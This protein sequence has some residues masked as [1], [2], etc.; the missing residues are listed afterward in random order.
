MGWDPI[1]ISNS[2]FCWYHAN[3]CPLIKVRIEV[4]RQS[5][6]KRQ[7]GGFLPDKAALYLAIIDN[8]IQILIYKRLKAAELIKNSPFK[9]V[10]KKH[11]KEKINGSKLI[12][13]LSLLSRTSNSLAM[14][15]L[16]NVRSL[17]FL[18]PSSRW[19]DGRVGG[20]QDGVL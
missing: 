2:Y 3:D 19:D 11:Y 20:I 13:T 12:P 9:Y 8:L 18:S 17:Y 4:T 7:F 5:C 14:V 6:R 15:V 16:I 10:T 1:L